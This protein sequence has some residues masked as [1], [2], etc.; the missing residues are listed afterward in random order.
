[1]TKTGLF[2]LPFLFL[3]LLSVNFVNADCT[4]ILV[5]H[6]NPLTGRIYWNYQIW[7][8]VAENCAR[9]KLVNGESIYVSFPIGNQLSCSVGLGS[10]FVSGNHTITCTANGS[11]CFA[12]GYA[13]N[14]GFRCGNNSV[15]VSS[16]RG[17]GGNNPPVFDC[18]YYGYAD[19]N[20]RGNTGYLK[21]PGAGTDR[22]SFGGDEVG[23]GYYSRG[24][25][26][27]D[28]TSKTETVSCAS[29]IDRMFINSIDSRCGCTPDGQEVCKTDGSG[30]SLICISNLWQTRT[31]KD[32]A[33]VLCTP[34]G[35]YEQCPGASAT[36]IVA[37]KDREP[38]K[39]GLRDS[40]GLTLPWNGNSF[41]MFSGQTIAETTFMFLD[42]YTLNP[43]G[44]KSSDSV[45]VSYSWN[46]TEISCTKSAGAL[47]YLEYGEYYSDSSYYNCT[48]NASH[49][50]SNVTITI[51]AN[52]TGSG[53][54]AVTNPILTK[55]FNVQV[56][57]DIAL[58]DNFQAIYIT[59]SIMAFSGRIISMSN[60]SKVPESLHP[61]LSVS[62]K[63]YRNDSTNTLVDAG[64]VYVH[65]QTDLNGIFGNTSV[66]GYGLGSRVEYTAIVGADGFT[67]KTYTNE[68]VYVTSARIR[69]LNCR[70]VPKNTTNYYYGSP[71]SGVSTGGYGEG[72]GGG[73]GGARGDEELFYTVPV[74]FECTF[75]LENVS[76]ISMSSLITESTISNADDPTNDIIYS[77]DV[78]V[79][80]N[81]SSGYVL[82]Y[83]LQ[84]AYYSDIDSADN[85][86]LLS[87]GRYVWRGGMLYHPVI[88]GVK[89]YVELLVNPLPFEMLSVTDSAVTFNQTVYYEGQN[90]MCQV[91]YNDPSDIIRNW[92]AELIGSAGHVFSLSDADAVNCSMNNNATCM[93]GSM[94]CEAVNGSYRQCVGEF[95]LYGLQKCIMR[96]ITGDN[97]SQCLQYKNFLFDG[98]NE[99]TLTCTVT[100]YKASGA[101]GSITRSATAKVFTTSNNFFDLRWL[102]WW[103]WFLFI[104]IAMIMLLMM[105]WR[106]QGGHRG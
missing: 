72:S 93:F 68:N 30:D 91:K 7:Q 104:I 37:N 53:T 47:S 69:Y 43:W 25:V 16:S 81:S 20:W 101:G 65:N 84:D 4:G 44:K 61:F 15:A 62:Y 75:E 3:F 79:P 8:P 29:T 78:S 1:M 63:L 51:S 32:G 12:A 27:F 105:K 58:L 19:Y 55:T 17:A 100:L 38:N 48:L 11:Y 31:C 89:T 92:R 26:C 59:D 50:I 103:S 86:K 2:I 52:L 28:M 87:S 66:V 45:A 9:T 70:N 39:I 74:A 21:T 57:R 18:A 60:L 10:D 71:Y 42:N 83:R 49:S 88:R 5:L 40:N 24:V 106:L 22:Y 82:R 36:V 85:P 90:V 97:T 35:L 67:N 41:D 80:F 54:V 73:G 96:S 56:I 98:G 23:G 13:D 99:Q 46:T 77:W 76:A 34:N 33:F 14:N 94:N 6:H 95:G 64:P 102:P